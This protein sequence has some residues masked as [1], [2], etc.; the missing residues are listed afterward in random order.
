M[1]GYS[2][3]HKAPE[4]LEPPFQ[5]GMVLLFCRD[6]VGVIYSSSRL[7]S[8]ITGTIG[9]YDY[10]VLEVM[11]CFFLFIGISSQNCYLMSNPIYITFY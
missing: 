5:R 10:G 11:F 6:A 3:F 9:I 2:T 8:N 7:N 1:K 4:V